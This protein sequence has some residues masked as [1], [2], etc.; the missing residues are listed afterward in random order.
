MF[1]QKRTPEEQFLA[2]FNSSLRSLGE[3]S[4][5]ETKSISEQMYRNHLTLS[6]ANIRFQPGA[7][8]TL[9]TLREQG[10]TTGIITNGIEQLQMAKIQA[11]GLQSKVDSVVVSAQARA[12]KPNARVFELA[13][14]KTDVA[15][16]QA[17]HI[18]DHAI[19]DVAGGIRAG[20]AGIFYD[21]TGKRADTAFADL[22]ESPSHIINRL[23]D[24]IELLNR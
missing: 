9:Q 10:F 11:L 4:T 17:W 21:P 1:E 23:S 24:V 3:L 7:V 18:G 15:A 2:C 14:A 5:T 6:C 8:E 12:H 20:L 13:L 16:T 22:E 19:N